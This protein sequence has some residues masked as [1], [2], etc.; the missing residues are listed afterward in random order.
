MAAPVTSKGVFSCAHK[1]T[2]SLSAASK[3]TVGGNPVQVFS[4]GG[5]TGAYGGCQNP[6]N[7]G[8]PCASTV[9]APPPNPGSAAKLTTAGLPALLSG[10]TAN[11]L[12]A[13]VSLTSVDPGQTKLTAS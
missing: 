2:M 6:Q 12:P 4:S 8:G 9:P 5:Y 11:T 7:A 3:L 10:L 1:G 13:G